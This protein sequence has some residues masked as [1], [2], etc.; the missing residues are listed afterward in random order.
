V[1]Y[2]PESHVLWSYIG[3]I[4]GIIAGICFFISHLWSYIFSI[5]AILFFII[6]IIL[7]VK[8]KNKHSINLTDEQ[9]RFL[10]YLSLEEKNILEDCFNENDKSITMPFARD[11][12]YLENLV[13]NNVVSKSNKTNWGQGDTFIIQQWAWEYLKDHKKLLNNI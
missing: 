11:N 10:Q 13:N 3:T 1:R 5:L 6:A 8:F 12:Q 4:F 7:F 9:I 2:S